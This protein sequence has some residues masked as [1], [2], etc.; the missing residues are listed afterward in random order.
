[1]S[2]LQ[3]YSAAGG[4]SRGTPAHAAV[5][6]EPPPFQRL[7]FGGRRLLGGCVAWDRASGLL[8]V[9]LK[10]EDSSRPGGGAAVAA[11]VAILDPQ[12]PEVSRFGEAALAWPAL[13]PR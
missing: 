11:S 9:E 13:R 8:A 6:A 3:P 2:S 1:M 12:A 10:A 5:P 7:Q 4:V